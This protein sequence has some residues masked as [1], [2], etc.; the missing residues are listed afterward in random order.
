MEDD[1][2]QQVVSFNIATEKYTKLAS[3][4]KV[5]WNAELN[6]SNGDWLVNND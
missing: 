2:Q 6:Q 5:F 3:G 4:E 1:R